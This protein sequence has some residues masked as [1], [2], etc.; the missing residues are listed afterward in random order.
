MKLGFL[1]V[2]FSDIPLKKVLDVIRPLKLQTVEL[3]TG[4]YPGDAHCNLKELLDS[5]P[6]RDALLSMLKGEGL[7]IS[8]LSCHGN[9]L[10]PDAAFAKKNIEVRPTRS[11]S[12][13]CL[14]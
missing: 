1:T 2:M 11:N 6:K 8:A 13:T 12:R 14:A 7:E 4:N 9:C 10:H 5:K 3:G